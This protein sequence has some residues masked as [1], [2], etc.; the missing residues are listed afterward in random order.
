MESTRLRGLDGRTIAWL[1]DSA[2]AL[3]LRNLTEAVRTARAAAAVAP[4]HPEVLRRLA[5]ALCAVGPSSEAVALMQRASAQAPDDPV[6]ANALGLVLRANARDAE[7]IA[8][9]RRAHA[10]APQSADIACNLAQLLDT[11]GSG[12]EAIAVLEQATATTPE[13]RAAHTALAE[14]LLRRRARIADAIAQLRY[15]LRVDPGDAWAWSALAEI[16]QT[17]FDAADIG[18]LEHLYASAGDEFEVRVR[19]GFALARAYEQS[20]DHARAIETYQQVNA[21]MHLRVHW[22]AAEFSRAVDAMLGA[23]AGPFAE[24]AENDRPRGAGIVF[25]VGLPRSG[26]TLIEQILASH[27]LVR[28]GGERLDLRDVIVEENERRHVDF[29]GWAGRA[30]AADWQRLGED[31][32]RRV[33]VARGD[34]QLFTDKLPGNWLWLGAALQMLP[35][36]RVVDCRRDRLETAWSCY[37]R[38]FSGGGQDF[39]YDFDALAQFIR[40]YERSMQHW[41]RLWSARIRTQHH[42]V[43][44]ADFGGQ[45]RELLAFCGLPFDPDCLAFHDNDREVGTISA[46]QV[47]EPMRRDTARAAV[48]AALLDPLR[49]ALGMPPFSV[50]A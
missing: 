12:D 25:I 26:T 7:A 13:H 20:A 29:A 16:E 15:L 8:A 33:A 36:A 50:G 35:G 18:A 19:A 39:S 23:C 9:L 48:Y 38:L 37:R 41:Q 30:G 40:D 32:L 42:E 3:R 17:H 11:Q 14:L 27:P 6:L 1:R 22:D 31:Y 45:V 24:S 21:A 43:L 2:A 4:D 10:L 34:G 47:R 28:A 49:T 46:S 44:A 5:L